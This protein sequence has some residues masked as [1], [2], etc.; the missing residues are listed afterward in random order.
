[1]EADL[2]T[3]EFTLAGIGNVACAPDSMFGHELEL[4]KLGFELERKNVY[5]K[6]RADYAASVG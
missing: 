2:G 1:M 6:L 5:G 3:V 4:V